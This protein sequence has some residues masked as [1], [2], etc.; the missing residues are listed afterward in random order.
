MYRQSLFR[1]RVAVVAL[2]TGA[3]GPVT[4]FVQVGPTAPLGRITAQAA[5]APAEPIRRLSVDDAV[6][7]GLEQNLGIQ[8]ERLNP[9]IQDVAVAQA[10]SFWSPQFG[11]SVT[12]QSLNTPAPT[13]ISS[14]L[15]TI[16]G[17]TFATS[18]GVNQ[19]L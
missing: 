17:A 15:S 11:T 14:G 4:A 16:T 8:I 6:R 7:L 12:N 13:T 19:V 2:T 18:L 5:A 10:R 1:L 9:Q 3:L